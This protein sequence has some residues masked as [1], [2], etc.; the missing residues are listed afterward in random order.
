M[1]FDDSNLPENRCFR[2]R[3]RIRR[4]VIIILILTAAVLAIHCTP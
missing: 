4:G 3:Q 1:K 2:R